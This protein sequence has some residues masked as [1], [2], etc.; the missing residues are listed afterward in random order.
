MS[1]RLSK[2]PY[3]TLHYTHPNIPPLCSFIDYID[4]LLFVNN[5]RKEGDRFIIRKNGAKAMMIFYCQIVNDDLMVDIHLDNDG[6]KVP[7]HSF[8]CPYDKMLKEII[9]RI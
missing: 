7:M 1:L 9:E 2:R 5:I 8:M 4:E 6:V 3:L